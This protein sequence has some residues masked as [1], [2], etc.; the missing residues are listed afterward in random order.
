VDNRRQPDPEVLP[1]KVAERVLKRASELE[2][3]RSAGTGVAQLREAAAEAGISTASFDAALGEVRDAEAGLPAPLVRER[4]RKHVWTF[5]AG[6][7]AVLLLMG[8]LIVPLLVAR[9]AVPTTIE[10]PR[11]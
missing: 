1:A 2:A 4:R 3:V 7:A 8:A 10:R 5:L 6:I 9:T 11:R